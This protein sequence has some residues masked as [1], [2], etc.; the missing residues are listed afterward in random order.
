MLRKLIMIQCCQSSPAQH[1][2]HLVS[3]NCK[4]RSSHT[5]DISRVDSTEPHQHLS[6]AHHLVGPGLLVEVGSEAV[7]DSVGGHLVTISVEILDLSVVSPLVRHVECGFDWTTIGI[8]S[9][10]EEVFIELFV[11]IIDSIVEGEED[12]LRNLIRRVTSGDISASAVT[13]LK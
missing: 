11:Q 1:V 8:V 2:E 3:T 9:V 6:L 12:K 7:S 13:I 10:S 5:L 4:E